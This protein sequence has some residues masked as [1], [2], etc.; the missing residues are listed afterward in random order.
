MISKILKLFFIKK[1]VKKSAMQN[2]TTPSFKTVQSIGVLLDGDCII[3]KE[4]I[5]NGLIKLGFNLSNVEFLV[6]QNKISKDEINQ[7]VFNIND[8]N[9]NG[10]F[11][12][13]EINEFVNK[14]F[15]V[16][17]NYFDDDI[18]ILHW[19]AL[20]S[21]ADFKV[22]FS[23]YNVNY[24]HLSISVE[25]ENYMSFLNELDRYLKILNKK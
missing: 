16:L 17:I 15:D 4:E 12:K 8:V 25:K 22:G 2:L 10:V 9:L 11:I 1:E 21:K 23:M 6:H 24:N 3:K 18:T 13:N 5:T 7:F 19:A 20:Q 14:A